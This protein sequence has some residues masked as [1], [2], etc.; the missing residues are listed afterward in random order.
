MAQRVVLGKVAT[1]DYRL[2]VSRQGFDVMNL[3]LAREN[4][5]FDTEWISTLLLVASGTTLVTYSFVNNEDYGVVPN[6]L[7]WPDLGF[8]PVFLPYVN[9]NET[10]PGFAYNPLSYMRFGV[11]RTGVDYIQN[12]LNGGSGTFALEYLVLRAPEGGV[13]G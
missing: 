1:N 7:T 12:T 5:F 6:I 4:L 11:K 3:S 8:I 13:L 9:P 2:R 10:N